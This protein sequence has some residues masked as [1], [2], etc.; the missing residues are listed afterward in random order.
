MYIS[1]NIFHKTEVLQ[2]SQRLL[3]TAVEPNKNGVLKTELQS[4]IA[5][6]E[7][8][9]EG[10]VRKIGDFSNHKVFL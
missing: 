7:E 8:V 9:W 6:L 1:L 10:E 4:S 5:K 3:R 2:Q